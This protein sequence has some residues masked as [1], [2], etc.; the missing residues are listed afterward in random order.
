MRVSTAAVLVATL[1]LAGCPVGISHPLGVP[2]SE[3][4]DLRLVGTWHTNEKSYHIV[5]VK[6]EAGTKQNALAVDVLEKGEMFAAASTKMTA[7]TTEIN[8]KHF[9]YAMPDG[10]SQ[11]YIQA[12]EVNG[13][14]L[15]LW[16]VSLLDG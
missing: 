10:E 12:Y 1:S 3:K 9:I 6:V 15:Q 16:D 11:W 5:T 4:P 8:G 2:G 14:K 13:N 7:Y